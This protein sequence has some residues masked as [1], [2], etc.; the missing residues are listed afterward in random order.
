MPH[1][2]AALGALVALAHGGGM[3]A[4][5]IGC[6]AV[7]GEL[8][9]GIALGPT[10][11]GRLDPALSAW[12]VAPGGETGG[13]LR[14]VGQLGVILLM[15][16][17]GLEMR[18]LLARRDLPTVAWIAALGVLVPIT[19]GVLLLMLVPVAR[20]VGAA[21]NVTALR[22]VLVTALAVT[23]IPVVTRI[24][25]DLGLLGTRLAR[26]VLGVAVLEDVL[27]YV[28]LSW[29]VSLAAG[30]TA[31]SARVPSLL[32]IEPGGMASIAWHVAASVALVW[33]GVHAGR[34][35]EVARRRGA[36]SP[37]LR[38][39]PLATVL[40][41]LF[42]CT[43]FAAVLGLVPMLGALVAGLA[44]AA[45]ERPGLRLAIGQVRA[46]ASALFVPVFFVLTGASL[47]LLGAFD[48]RSCIALLTV[49]VLA[50]GVGVWLGAR[51]AGESRSSTRALVVSLNARGGP[52][53]VLATT[54]F[55]AGIV[56]A[57]MYTS[58]ILLAV[59]T[60]IGAGAWL[61]RFARTAA[62]PTHHDHHPENAAWPRPT[63][64]APSI[65]SAMGARS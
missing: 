62:L 55:A 40:A 47:D 59:L 10:L 25:A 38:R 23:S 12:L 50:K 6:P 31:E 26:L 30:S 5:R 8:V 2:L 33:G 37:L 53:I 9:A 3:L 32:G 54:A 58:L 1:L 49:G 24:F 41:F 57:R 43:A 64:P 16:G 19:I 44:L 20:Y 36:G 42:A 11:L 61:A 15:F 52:G 17:A 4:Q 60:S 65:S 48:P 14:F 63:P 56:D 13:A 27:V 28:A 51:L 39:N 21:D 34:V 35:V 45:S 7:V 29:A 18:S 22:V 46:V